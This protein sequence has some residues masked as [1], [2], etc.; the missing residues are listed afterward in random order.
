MV[1]DP[2][3]AILDAVAARGGQLALR[4]RGL[5]CRLPPGETLP[6]TLAADIRAHKPALIA[7]IVGGAEYAPLD[8]GIAADEARKR[9]RAEIVARLD[10]L[11]ARAARPDAAPL[12]RQLA[13]DWRAIL[14][15]KEGMTMA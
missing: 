14:A 12:D 3:L 11:V 8:P 7:A 13:A 4:D 15:A 6:P 10:R 2:V 1:R 9:P 5:V